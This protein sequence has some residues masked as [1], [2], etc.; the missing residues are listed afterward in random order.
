M[1]SNTALNMLLVFASIYVLKAGSFIIMPFV[2]ALFMWALIWLLDTA[3]DSLF[4][5]RLRL[6]R[7]TAHLSR[8]FSIVTIIGIFYFALV[9]IKDNITGVMNSFGAYQ[10][11]LDE[12]IAGAGRRLNIDLSGRADELIRGLDMKH[13]TGQVLQGFASFLSSTTLIVIYLI[14]LLWE[15]KS[16]GRKLPLLLTD[17]KKVRE[18]RGLISKTLAKI[19]IYLSIKT[20]DS[21]I[22][23]ALCYAVMSWVGLDFAEF[24]AILLFLFNF[25]PTIG[26]IAASALPMALALLQFNGSL[27]PFLVVTIGITAVQLLVGYILE[28][29][30]MG[31]SI[32]LSPIVQIL[33][34]VAW[35]YIWGIMGMFLC[36]PIMMILSIILYNIPSTRKIAIMMSEDGTSI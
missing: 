23:C 21:L 7:F 17:G 26:S 16:L 9:V 28:P 18:V 29:K 2:V 11:N 31:R 8:L 20:L 14:F 12:I 35:G 5:E 36:I 30:L 10:S 6:P 3:F 13:L 25:I 4:L 1:K 33:S 22:I 15:E 19:K 27:V 32:N 34:L 24:W